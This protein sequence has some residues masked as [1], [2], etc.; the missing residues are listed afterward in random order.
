MIFQNKER[1]KDGQAP[2]SSMLMASLA[3]GFM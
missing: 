1:G 2:Q 3:N